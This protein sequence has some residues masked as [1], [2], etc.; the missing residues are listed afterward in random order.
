VGVRFSRGS[1]GHN[2]RFSQDPFY[3]FHF[4]FS[5]IV[6]CKNRQ[7][8]VH[9]P[10]HSNRT[11]STTYYR[12]VIMRYSLLAALLVTEFC[13]DG[14]LADIAAAPRQLQDQTICD[15]LLGEIEDDTTA[16]EIQDSCQCSA[17]SGGDTRLACRRNNACLSSDGGDPM[18][19]DFSAIFTKDGEGLSFSQTIT[20]KTCF[21]YPSDVNDGK[22]VCVSTVR[23]GLGTVAT[24]QI[25]VGTENLCRLCRFCPIDRISF[26]CSNLGYED[27]TA[28]GDNNTDDS[29]LNFLYKPELVSGCGGGSGGSGGSGSPTASPSG[30]AGMFI[31][32][33][34]A[35]F[36]LVP[37]LLMG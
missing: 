5:S 20:A 23:D 32:M 3:I 30:G 15:E 37:V 6:S 2:V 14:V 9:N 24:C 26:D 19:G 1:V 11:Q 10:Y 33:M 18:Q 21:T 7:L 31:A 27:R 35:V 4:P 36:G 12:P 13:P 8:G 29:I 28:C 17:I 22:K 16:M 25:Q 34:A